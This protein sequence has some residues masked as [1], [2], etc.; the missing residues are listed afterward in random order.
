MNKL[1][2]TNEKLE[3]HNKRDFE[4]EENITNKILN[5]FHLLKLTIDNMWTRFFRV[6][7]A[8]IIKNIILI[9]IIYF[10]I[11]LS[12][13]MKSIEYIKNVMFVFITTMIVLFVIYWQFLDV[14][15]IQELKELEN[16]ID[17]KKENLY[18]FIIS[19]VNVR[20]IKEKPWL[21]KKEELK[22]FL[23][24][25]VNLVKEVVFDFTIIIF[26]LI[27]I[28]ISKISFGIKEQKIY[29]LLIALFRILNSIF[30][31]NQSREL[32][33]E[34]TLDNTKNLE[35]SGEIFNEKI[36]KLKLWFWTLFSI[37]PACKRLIINILSF[38]LLFV[39]NSF[40][41]N[42]LLL[43][44]EKLF[45]KSNKENK[46][47]KKNY[48]NNKL[49]IKA[50]KSFYSIYSLILTIT[51]LICI[52]FLCLWK[53]QTLFE[54]LIK[55]ITSFKEIN[56]EKD[57]NT[58]IFREVQIIEP[59]LKIFNS[60]SKIINLIDTILFIILILFIYLFIFS[61][62]EI[63][64]YIFY[65]LNIIECNNQNM[66]TFYKII[67]N[68]MPFSLY[69]SSTI[70]IKKINCIK[71]DEN[72]LKSGLNIL[73][74]NIYEEFIVNI[75]TEMRDSIIKIY[76]NKI[77]YIFLKYI[78]PLYIYENFIDLNNFKFQSAF[79]YDLQNN[80]SEFLKI[81]CEKFSFDVFKKKINSEEEY[82]VNLIYCL[83]KKIPVLFLGEK[84]HNHI[85][86][87]N[88]IIK[89][90]NKFDTILIYKKV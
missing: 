88:D 34:P 6:I 57:R 24:L 26:F 49:T 16:F 79:L 69:G 75:S 90:D 61:L 53:V 22:S 77:N 1:N 11:T 23:N 38:S 20:K 4:K 82:I 8:R 13:I 28:F 43:D 31:T 80:K 40:S 19:N 63:F 44:S 68:L 45:H 5:P 9:S 42:K 74:K 17:F 21:F 33:K 39:N 12:S 73:D 10:S 14:Y 37:L 47:Y 48:Y 89:N 85:N 30:I 86:I 18:Q 83:S 55:E 51:I 52:I 65:M 50:L 76:E 66:N 72:E 71:I 2:T 46:E 25:F 32:I 59:A 35:F 70:N 29:N 56:R 87:L 3:L 58:K 36:I 15:Y 27:L 67:K 41:E 7:I 81:L 84:N 78:N 62:L 60:F 64:Y 54:D